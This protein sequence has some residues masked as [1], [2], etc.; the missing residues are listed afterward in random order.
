MRRL[1]EKTGSI[2]KGMDITPLDC[3]IE[4]RTTE[5]YNLTHDYERGE[6]DLKNS[7]VIIEALYKKGMINMETL[8][9]IQRKYGGV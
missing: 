1:V 2:T 3:T 9:K 8:L 4:S 6:G 7:L 5:C